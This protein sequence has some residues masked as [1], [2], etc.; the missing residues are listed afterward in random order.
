MTTQHHLD[1]NAAVGLFT[2][3]VGIDLTTAMV[4]CGT[5]GQDGGFAES[6]LYGRGPGYVFRC[7]KCQ[8][9]IARLVRTPTTV[10]LD[11][12]GARSW[13]LPAQS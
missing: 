1:A 9:I 3:A 5:C 10:W 4:T 11:F 6:H 2:E 13:R 8:A 7:P 12:S